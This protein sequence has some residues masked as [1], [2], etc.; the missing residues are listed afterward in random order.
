MRPFVKS[1]WPLV[2]DN[3]NYYYTWVQ[4]QTCCPWCREY[5]LQWAV[6]QPMTPC[7]CTQTLLGPQVPPSASCNINNVFHHCSLLST[8]RTVSFSTLTLSV[9][10]QFVK[11]HCLLSPQRLSSG[12]GGG[13]RFQER[14]E[15]KSDNPSLPGK[16]P[17][18]WRWCGGGLHITDEWYQNL[19]A[20]KSESPNLA[21]LHKLTRL[22]QSVLSKLR[23]VPKSSQ[24]GLAPRIEKFWYK[25]S[26]SV[27]QARCLS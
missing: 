16:W 14:T 9:G 18:E 7:W 4:Q 10:W 17:L 21:S 11:N 26:T 23:S 22:I 2:T 19:V 8:S 3:Y 12:T 20:R 24:T 6:R 25:W 1:L 5:H 15:R 27:L 13:K